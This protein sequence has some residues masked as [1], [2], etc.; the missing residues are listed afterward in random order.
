MSTQPVVMITG[1]ARGLGSELVRAFSKHGYQVFATA[2][3]LPE[4][5]VVGVTWHELDVTDDAQCKKAMV[6]A[7]DKFGR[8]DVLINNASSYEGSI[9]LAEMGEKDIDRE[10]KT[11]LRAPIYLS[12]LYVE[13]MRPQ[14][15]GKI[16]FISSVAGLPGEPKCELH[17][18]YSAAKAGL[19]RFAECLHEDIQSFGMKA[20][21]V[22]P[23][24][25]RSGLD[26][27]ELVTQ[28]AISY[29]SVARSIVNIAMSDDNVSVSKSILR[30]VR[31]PDCGN[32]N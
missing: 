15:S 23:S 1:A 18:V 17:S 12:K 30:P 11:T 29:D 5:P 16:I 19:I 2:R 20:H 24:S 26:E 3:T 4:K 27:A 6:A 9:T 22:V 8:I 32:G 7:F 28:K 21:V 31:V 13:L 25:M 10:L 14:Q